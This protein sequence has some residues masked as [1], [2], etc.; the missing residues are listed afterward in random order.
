[1]GNLAKPPDRPAVK[2]LSEI[3]VPALILVGEYDI[4]DVHAHS[5]VIEAGIPKAKREI[6]FKSGHLIP[7]EQPQAFNA[8]VLR[9]LDSLGEAF[10]KDGQKDL[11]I[12]YYEKSL[13]LYPRNTHAK[14]ILKDLKK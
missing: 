14:R 5:G 3:K 4:P 11:A 8:S 2:Y 7:L 6:I 10:L 12:E 13:E 9:F 1:M